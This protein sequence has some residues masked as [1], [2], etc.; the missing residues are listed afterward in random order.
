MGIFSFINYFSSNESLYKNAL[1]AFKNDDNA[2]GLEYLSY[3][4]TSFFSKDSKEDIIKSLPSDELLTS[5]LLSLIADDYSL[6]NS[7]AA[8]IVLNSVRKHESFSIFAEND[9]VKLIADRY[10]IVKACK[11]AVQNDICLTTKLY[12]EFLDNLASSGKYG[13]IAEISELVK[14]QVDNLLKPYNEDYYGISKI[15][16]SYFI[17][18]LAEMLDESANVLT[19]NHSFYNIYPRKYLADMMDCLLKDHS[20]DY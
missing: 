20:A 12:C 18:H 13:D 2:V 16:K 7:H 17:G 14:N 3:I 15:N 9:F 4:S 5:K 1:D 8:M 10:G 19:D 11:F 6:V